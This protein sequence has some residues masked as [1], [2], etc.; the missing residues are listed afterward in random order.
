MVNPFMCV[1]STRGSADTII[2][3]LVLQVIL[4][5][6][7]KK[8][9]VAGIFYGFCVH[10]KIY[11]ILYSIPF[12]LFIDRPMNL[13]KRELFDKF[14]T[15]NRLVFTFVSAS[16]FLALMGIFYLIYGYHFLYEGYLYHLVRKDNRHNISLFFY[17]IYLNFEELTQV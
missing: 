9:I 1:I 11:P 3:T 15:Y 7:Q 14:F 17:Y 5:L 16:M 8:Y 13:E 10:F 2:C 12:Y 6:L 4:L